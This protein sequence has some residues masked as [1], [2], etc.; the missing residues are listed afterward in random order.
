MY[1]TAQ[2]MGLDAE[3]GESFTL[4]TKD[5]C[6]IYD[7]D[8]DIKIDSLGK[9]GDVCTWNAN[10]SVGGTDVLFDIDFFGLRQE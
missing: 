5:P 4:E 3:S 9:E 1:I 7:T 8:Q 2:L 6:P 10:L